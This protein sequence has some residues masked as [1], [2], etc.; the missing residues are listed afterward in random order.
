[1]TS[2]YSCDSN[3]VDAEQYPP[4]NVVGPDIPAADILIRGNATRWAVLN[5][6]RRFFAARGR[7][8]VEHVIIGALLLVPGTVDH[9]I[10]V[11]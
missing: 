3:E 11:R 4:R 5:A 2:H 6:R 7:R 10:P 8:S 1:M 9:R